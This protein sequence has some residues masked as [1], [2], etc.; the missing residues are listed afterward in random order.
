ML[1]SLGGSHGPVINVLKRYLKQE[2]VDKNKVPDEGQVYVDG[3]ENCSGVNAPVPIQHNYSDCGLY[4]M[5]FAETFLKKTA[6]VLDF[7]GSVRL[8][9][10]LEPFSILLD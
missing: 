10:C 8:C 4:V 5:H 9:Q 3:K 1:D 6:D 7:V 2:A